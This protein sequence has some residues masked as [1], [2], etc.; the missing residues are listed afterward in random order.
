MDCNGNQSTS[1]D[2][3]TE[4]NHNLRESEVLH[5]EVPPISSGDVLVDRKSIFQA[6]VA[7]IKSKEEVG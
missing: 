5:I 3:G 4:L 2:E 6:H 7:H 1:S